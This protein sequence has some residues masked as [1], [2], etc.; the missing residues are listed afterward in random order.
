MIMEQHNDQQERVFEIPSSNLAKF[1]EKWEKLVRR[2]NKLGIIPPSY[3]I[4]KEEPKTRTVKR[5]RYDETKGCD[6]VYE[7]EVVYLVHHVV[8]HNPLVIVAGWEFVATL[9]HTEEGNITHNISGKDL[10]AKYRDCSAWCDHC[11]TNRYRKETFVVVKD[12]EYQQV[13]RN[14]LADF[15][16]VDGTHAA[17]MAEIYYTAGELGSASENEGW[18][19]GHGESYDFVEAYLT[20]VAEVISIKG[21]VSRGQAREKDLPATADIAYSH[22]HP[23]AFQRAKDRLYDQP[24]DKSKET[25]KAAVAWC[26]ALPDSEV[27]ASEYLHNI[28]VIARRGVIGPK[29]YGF[30]ASIVSGY[31]RALVDAANREMRARRAGASIHVGTI[32]KR[33]E[34][35]VM[36][37]RVQNLESNFGTTYLHHMSDTDGNCLKWF[38]SN[39][40]LDTGMIMQ[41]KGTVKK[42]DEYNGMKQTIL[43]RVAVVEAKQ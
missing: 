4:V 15:L 28:R 7:D 17:A 19:G 29:Q 43:S 33:Q 37:E 23:P 6:V 25:A 22:M 14:C 26:E 13:G 18:G 39:K 5:E 16:G 42:H 27:E 34:F 41:I 11:K 38:S 20:H 31:Q 21:W 36:V 10:P 3:V 35:T 9:E 12:A 24:S 1:E 30:A 2:A 8:I 40:V 32:G